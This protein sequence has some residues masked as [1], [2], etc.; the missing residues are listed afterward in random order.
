MCEEFPT[1]LVITACQFVMKVGLLGGF[2]SQKEASWFGD[3][4]IWVLSIFLVDIMLLDL[5]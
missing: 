3:L 4:Q 2:V 5:G 1:G